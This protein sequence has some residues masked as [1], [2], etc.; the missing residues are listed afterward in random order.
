M[1]HLSKRKNLTEWLDYIEHLHSAE[2]EF[3]LTRVNQVFNALFPNGLD[4]RVIT[5]GGTNGKGSTCTLI[6]KILLDA[7]YSCGKNT[8]PHIVNFNERVAINGNFASDDELVDAFE[9]IDLKRQKI[10][11]TYF[12]FTFLAALVIFQKREVDFAICE[13][14]MGGRLDA[15]NILSPEA[16]IITNIGLDH[17]QWLGNTREAIALEKVAISRPHKPCI[18][19]DADF[20][21]KSCDY[22]LEK[23]SKGLI[24]SKDF[25]IDS[26]E[27]P[28]WQIIVSEFDEYFPDRDE[29]LLKNLPKLEAVHHYQNAS[30]AILALLSMKNVKINSVGIKKALTDSHIIGRCQILNQA[31][32]IIVD[33]AHNIDSVKALCQFVRLKKSK[34]AN[35]GKTIAII[36]MLDDK[37][38]NASLQQINEEIDE[39][40]I[41][42]LPVTRAANIEKIKSAIQFA[43]GNSKKG[44]I[45]NLKKSLIVKEF[46]SIKTAFTQVKKSIK[47]SDCVVVFGSFFV[48]S[49]ILHDS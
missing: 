35:Q 39:W 18:V 15:V 1:A 17:T 20:P 7:G 46:D 10:L 9:T 45:K 3:G 30:C 41:A 11:L 43:Q 16:S 8:S 44:S 21:T 13:V 38:M 23:K 2:I 37:D 19:G 12:E 24:Y 28:S 33:V 40:Y 36:S 48:V 34:I 25:H 32:L 22:L 49:D 31:P 4:C 5:V 6:E 47:P 27:A 26:N 29:S 42:E 14:G